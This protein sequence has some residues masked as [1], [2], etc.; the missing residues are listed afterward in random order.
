MI[1]RHVLALNVL[2]NGYKYVVVLEDTQTYQL[3]TKTFRTG[4]LATGV[5][6]G[7]LTKPHTRSLILADYLGRAFQVAPRLGLVSGFL[8]QSFTYLGTFHNFNSESFERNQLLSCVL[9]MV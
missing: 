9:Q 1:L 7:N 5:W 2:A 3:D 6:N 8:D 4:D